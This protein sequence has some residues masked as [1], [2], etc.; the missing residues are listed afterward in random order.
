MGRTSVKDFGQ[1]KTFSSEAAGVWPLRV[2]ETQQGCYDRLMLRTRESDSNANGAFWDCVVG[3]ERAEENWIY[4]KSSD[5]TESARAIERCSNS[6]S[7]E[8]ELTLASSSVKKIHIY[9][10]QKTGTNIH[11]MCVPTWRWRGFSL[12]NKSRRIS[13]GDVR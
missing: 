12:Q 7:N 1:H 9:Q 3:Q 10:V 6:A 4:A 5:A 13:T 2:S 8:K 11:Y